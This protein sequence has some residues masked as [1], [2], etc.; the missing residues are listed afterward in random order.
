MVL[1]E[2]SGPGIQRTNRI[3]DQGLVRLKRQLET[4][5]RPSK[6]VLAQW[7]RRYGDRARDL[8]SGYGVDVD[9]IG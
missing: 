2:E 3:A 1:I 6:L 7:I 4:G 8:L 5:A 9:E